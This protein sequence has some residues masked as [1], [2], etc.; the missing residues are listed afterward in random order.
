MCREIARHTFDAMGSRCELLAVGL[1]VH[2]L[3]KAEAWVR[4]AEARFSR[5]D[6]DS[7][8]ST[9]NRSGGNW[10]AVSA[11]MAR[12]L[13]ACLDAYGRSEGLVNAAVLTALVAAGYSRRF[14][15]GL[16]APAAFDPHPV[17]ALPE[18]L[19]LDARGR[20]ARLALGCGLD[21]G[22]VAKGVLADELA[23]HLGENVVCNL[24][25]DL[26]A[27]GDGLGGGWLV[28]L[29]DGRTVA[30]ANGALGTS[31][32]TRRRWGDAFH[33][34][35]DPRTGAPTTSDVTL[36]SV[37]AEDALSAEIYAKTALLLGATAGARFLRARGLFH[38]MQGQ[39]VE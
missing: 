18:V 20:R 26:R 32:T 35:I 16:R 8:L 13:N 34:L 33:H 6:G 5:F 7:E 22:G 39:A 15:D 21:A 37:A 14:A 4:S 30:V 29:P 3:R 25:G 31:G 19:E 2:E 27:R 12:M 38:V 17:P 9:L 24:G 10:V 23:A 11:P 1:P 28:G 36:V